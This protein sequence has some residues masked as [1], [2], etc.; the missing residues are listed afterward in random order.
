[1]KKCNAFTLI[2]FLVVIMILVV[3]FLAVPVGYVGWS[4]HKDNVRYEEFNR[5]NPDVLTKGEFVNILDRHPDGA[6]PVDPRAKEEALALSRELKAVADDV[7]DLANTEHL[8]EW[9]NQRNAV[10][11]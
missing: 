4:I 1:M 7:V 5:E 10:D 6:Y 11:E 2:E 9:L 8:Q 3:L